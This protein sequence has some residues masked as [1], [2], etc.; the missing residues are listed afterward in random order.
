MEPPQGRKGKDRLVIEFEDE[1]QHSPPPPPP[2]ASQLI[3]GSGSRADSPPSDSIA[4]LREAIDA[5]I[6]SEAS[7]RVSPEATRLFDAT[8]HVLTTPRWPE[9]LDLLQRTYDQAKGGPSSSVIA[10]AVLRD[11]DREFHGHGIAGLEIE[12]FEFV[13]GRAEVPG[14]GFG[15]SGTPAGA[16]IP[17]SLD[18]SEGIWIVLGAEVQLFTPLGPEPEDTPDRPLDATGIDGLIGLEYGLGLLKRHLWGIAMI[19]FAADRIFGFV[20]EDEI[21]MRKESPE[22][23]AMPFVEVSGADGGSGS[24]LGFSVPR[25]LFTD[26]EI[27]R[28]FGNKKLPYINLNGECSVSVDTHRMVDENRKVVMPP[29]GHVAQAVASFLPERD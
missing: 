11:D 6:R 9:A 20:Y 23:L 24:V 26:S 22:T 13:G 29:K 3:T 28:G 2:S 27:S 21:P 17:W 15:L 7:S 25:S 19:A 5:V 4:S 16:V 14:L 1:P 12:R 18:P 8:D 10:L